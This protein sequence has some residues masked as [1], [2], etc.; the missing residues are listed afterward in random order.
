MTVNAVGVFAPVNGYSEGNRRPISS[1]QAWSLAFGCIVGWGAF[2]M[3]G[4]AF[5]PKAGPLGT[6]FAML[7]SVLIMLMIGANYCYM[8]NRM[9][10]EGGVYAYTK[11]AFGSDQAFLCSW[12]LSLCYIS[13]IPYNATGLV[14]LAR[15]YLLS[16]FQFGF[17]YRIMGFDLFFGE[18]FLAEV[19]LFFFG[20]ITIYAGRIAGY[21]HTLLAVLLFAGIAL[22]LV[23]AA[24]S[25]DI[26]QAAYPAGLGP[27][28]S[29]RGVFSLILLAPFAFVG[30]DT[31]SFSTGEFR[32]PVRKSFRII[33]AAIVSGGFVY[34]ALTWLAAAIVP[35]GYPNWEAYVS[36]IGTY[37]GLK[38]LPALNAARTLYATP[39]ALALG[40]C[41]LSAILTSII[42][43]YRAAGRVL[44]AMAGG[45]ILPK[46]LFS[47]SLSMLFIMAVSM[48]G[49][50]SG[51]TV[52][53][54]TVEMSTVGAAIAFAYTSAA[55]FRL[56]KA[57]GH[58][59]AMVTG[60]L[61]TVIS[62]AFLAA[63]LIPSLL[64][65]ES[66]SSQSYLMLSV[67][68][69]LGY[70]FYWRSLRGSPA[71]GERHSIGAGIVLFLM[72]FFSSTM[73]FLERTREIQDVNLL[74]STVVRSSMVELI[75]ILIGTLAFF[76]IDAQL[77]KRQHELEKEKIKAEESSRAKSTFLFNM[78]HDIRTPMNAIIGY[79]N[80]A[81][82]E[83]GTSPQVTDYLTKIEASSRHLLAL[84]NDILEMSRIESGRMELEPVP[85]DICR[86]LAE[87]RDLFATQMSGKQICFT[88]DTR[89]VSDRFVLIDANRF[90]RVLLNLLSNAYKFTPE[91][92]SVTV[93]LRE[94]E[95]QSAAAAE[96]ELSVR[97]TGIGMSAEFAAKVFDAFER[98]RTSTVSGIQGTGLGMSITRSIVDL[99]GGEIAVYTAPGE[100]TEFVIRLTLP[101]ADADSI[102]NA[103]PARRVEPIDFSKLRLLLVEDNEI[104][105]EIASLVLEEAG[106]SLECAVNGREAVEKVAASEPGWYDAVLMDV[107]MPVMN[108]YE[109]TRAI[110]S[111]DDGRLSRLPII[112]MTANAFSEDIQNAKDAGMD[113][114]IAKPL[115]VSVMLQTLSEVLG[116]S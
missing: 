25:R 79:T 72:I 106:F 54:W 85:T 97:D 80:L 68:S 87:A 73:W 101:L 11:A 114:H 20:T 45:G 4:T 113:A 37:N 51:S 46:R 88:V 81:L 96:Y 62:A 83:N 16:A 15:S 14:L 12:F 76:L 35:P 92:G 70:I 42:G 52:L 67:W 60:A 47:R 66:L 82:Q 44:S 40:F 74:H 36:E 8:M 71:Q 48:I 19:V 109:A 57:A 7:I 112:A 3:P 49:L 78:S 58:R 21:L 84:I 2:I 77:R 115:D 34:A 59:G 56:A 9:P 111:L 13:L 33:A 22:F 50:F 38:A 30:F 89:S 6:L 75:L 86:V 65:S 116:K 41:A 103:E 26:T 105:R 17:H 98:E 28:G 108:G 63:L 32:F 55:A 99:M 29:G 1:L 10:G 95:K 100:G 31:L 18:L 27:D 43:F 110:R 107:Q 102:Q 91:G 69:I 104:N 94:Q 23:F 93:L 61:G 90:N 39:G 64:E 5:L 24:A 53:N